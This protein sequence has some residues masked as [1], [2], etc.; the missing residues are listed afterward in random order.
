[1]LSTKDLAPKVISEILRDQPLSPAKVQFAWRASVGSSMAR[2][3]SV[4]L[5]ANGT[6]IVL[7]VGE[8]WRRETVRSTRVIKQRLTDLLGGN[9][10][11][12]VT[13]KGKT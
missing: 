7:A 12:R 10:I 6:L 8:H 13:V 1:M 2:A 9:V 5:E 4:T 3:T 11:R